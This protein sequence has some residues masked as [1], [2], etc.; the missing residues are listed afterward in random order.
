MPK[1]SVHTDTDEYFYSK[2]YAFLPFRNEKELIYPYNVNNA[3]DAFR[4]K[5]SQFDASACSAANIH[6]ELIK[7]VHIIRSM[8]SGEIDNAP[9]LTQIQH[10]WEHCKA[11]IKRL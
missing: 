1:L 4:A 2:L 9:S 7:A 11:I 3:Y 8:A 10:T 6:D 5:R